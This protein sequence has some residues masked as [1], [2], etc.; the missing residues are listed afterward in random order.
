MCEKAAK[1]TR[2]VFKPHSTIASTSSTLIH[3]HALPGPYRI[4]ESREI[5]GI[6]PC[7]PRQQESR[8]SRGSRNP[9]APLVCQQLPLVGPSASRYVAM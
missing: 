3:F 6:E 4:K 2:G 5:L 1:N 7:T 8:E 9:V